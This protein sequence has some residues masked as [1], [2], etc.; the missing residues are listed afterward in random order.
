[1]WR[2]AFTITL[3]L[4]AVIGLSDECYQLLNPERAFDLFDFAADILG[5]LCFVTLLK[6]WNGYHA[7][8]TWKI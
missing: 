8:S 3:L 4:S 1:K 6:W 2:P 5:A 7:G